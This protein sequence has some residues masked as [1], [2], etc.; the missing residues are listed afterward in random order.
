MQCFQLA[1]LI[2]FFLATGVAQLALGQT[3]GPQ[4]GAA[5]DEFNRGSRRIEAV[6]AQDAKL[7][8]SLIPLA[9]PPNESASEGELQLCGFTLAGTSKNSANG[10]KIV[11]F[12]RLRGE[13]IYSSLPLTTNDAVI[14][15]LNPNDPAVDE[16][17]TSITCQAISG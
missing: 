1:N 17:A 13:L 15:S 5:W 16:D 2:L 3:F 14:L 12:G 10:W 7:E 6:E 11:P 9:T 4:E 8:Q